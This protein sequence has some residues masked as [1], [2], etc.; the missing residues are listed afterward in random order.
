M[1]FFD[2]AIWTWT[3]NFLDRAGR[4]SSMS[5]GFR[6]GAGGFATEA[7]ARAQLLSIATAAQAVSNAMVTGT[8]L[9]TNTVDAAAAAGGA[10]EK[11]RTIEDRV[12]LDLG[13]ADG[14]NRPTPIRLP[15]PKETIL[16][17]DAETADAAD[18]AV[19][20]LL[21]YLATKAYSYGK[22]RLIEYVAGWRERGNMRALPRGVKQLA[23]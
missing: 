12:R 16:L 4:K 18:E 22:S 23:A 11:Y 20:A 1:A 2:N 13:P 14:Q 10:G 3:I 9:R 17:P 21:S 8:V 6:V 5:G 7:L 19:A 15:Q